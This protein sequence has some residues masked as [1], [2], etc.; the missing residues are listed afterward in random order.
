M[1]EDTTSINYDQFSDKRKRELEDYRFSQ[2]LRAIVVETNDPLN[3][4]RIRFRCPELHDSDLIPGQCPWAVPA[5][6]VG[7]PNSGDWGNP[8]IGDVIFICWEKD[9]PY[10]PIYIAAANPTRRKFYPVESVHT[11]TPVYLNIDGAVSNSTSNAPNPP[12]DY[13]SDYL[14]KDNRPMSRG[15]KDRYGNTIFMG[16]VG[17]F[18]STHS[19]ASTVNGVDS[20]TQR[21]FDNS[22]LNPKLN[23]PDQ[24]YMSLTTKYSN[25][26]ILS[27]IGYDWQKGDTGSEGEFTGDFDKDIKFE[28]DRHKLLQRII[29]E[30]KPTGLDQ[31]RIEFRTRAG[32]KFELRDTGWNKTRDGEFSSG[33]R[34]IS[35]SDKDHRWVKLVTKG[36]NLIQLIDIGSDPEN[37][38]YYKSELI[39][40]IGASH[41]EE[42]FGEDARQIRFVTRYGFKMVLDDRGSSK[43]EAELK[44]T[45]RGNGFLVKG[46]RSKTVG[47]DRTTSSSSESNQRG[48]GIEFNEKDQINALKMYSP[49]SQLIEI[50]DKEEYTLVCTNLPHDVSRPWVGTKDNEFSLHSG[51]FNK[52]DTKTFHL[53]L[54]KK[55]EYL[56]LKSPKLQGLEVRDKEE[57]VEM[58]DDSDRGIFASNQKKFI[59]FRSVTELNAFLLIDDDKNQ[60]LIQNNS[61]KIQISA[62][63]PIEVISDDDISLKGNNINIKAK[64]S[65]NF[66]ASGISGKIAGGKFGV[67]S[68]I[69]AKNV[70]AFIPEAETPTI[71]SGFG[72][73]KPKPISGATP[74]IN[75]VEISR[76]DLSPKE[77]PDERGFAP[78][79]PTSAV[80]ESVI[81]G[82]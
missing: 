16:S 47:D 9:H 8:C 17:F 50:N 56:R 78:N 66:Q 29:S 74:N 52:N 12:D 69:H 11:K 64:S 36:G 5:P 4:G 1:S 39:K 81:K 25:M 68:D 10:A 2:F 20:V 38:N 43:T 53:L 30:D 46:R 21:N 63:G 13:N 27:D 58:R 80:D 37:D 31:R 67:D 7:G 18:P 3:I 72:I 76:E 61:G 33:R 49:N 51:R 19:S 60:V 42:N 26:I 82:F 23:N 70:Y 35:Q 14:P 34:T 55:N 44:E 48:F 22:N 77:D 54:D 62:S 59:V 28:S 24:K 65:I 6:Q 15:L 32:H 57:F 79:T 45:P 73:A 71:T 75:K 41:N 40:D